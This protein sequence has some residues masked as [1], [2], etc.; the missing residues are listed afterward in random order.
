LG[1]WGLSLTQNFQKRYHDSA[2]SVTDEFRYVNAYDT[3]DGQLYFTG[4]KDMK[5]TLGVR[6]LFNAV[7]PY[8]NYAATTNNFIGGYDVS[9]GDPLQR[10]V[11]LRAQYSIR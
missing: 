5:L 10:F 7:P 11:Y 4:V 9:Y 3:I 6:N 8:A 2:S 1:S